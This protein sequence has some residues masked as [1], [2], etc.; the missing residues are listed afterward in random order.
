MNTLKRP[1]ALL[2]AGAALAWLLTGMPV[3]AS[4]IISA[5]ADLPPDGLYVADSG[6]F[7][8]SA[9]GVTVASP[10]VRPLVSTAVR[11]DD[12]TDEQVVFEAIF[13]G[14]ETA[15]GIGTVSMTGPVTIVAREKA[16][17]TTGT[18]DT[19]IVSMSLAGGTVSQPIL[20]RE[21]L[22]LESLGT[23]VIADIGG[24]QFQIDSFFDVFTEL[25][26]DG[27]STWVP[28]DTS[29]RLTLTTP[30]PAALT[31][32]MLAGVALG[33]RRVLSRTRRRQHRR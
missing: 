7:E 29:T 26:L 14:V 25:S 10:V 13:E 17:E 1:R 9:A 2:V 3:G 18:F 21:S 30:E 5:T 16:G 31:L 20:V 24:G 28:S 33:V 27:G 15:L 12:G 11:S 23:T 4:G 22:G 19:E 6:A 8:Y 32:L